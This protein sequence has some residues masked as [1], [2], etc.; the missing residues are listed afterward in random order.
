MAP[1]TG[2][3][4]YFADQQRDAEYGRAYKAAQARIRQ[5]DAL[6]RALDERRI[7]RG[8]SKAE[9]ARSAGVQPEAVR[10]LFTMNAPNPTANT[11][12]ALASALDLELVTRPTKKPTVKAK[13]AKKTPRRR[14]AARV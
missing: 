3:E 7:A 9:L 6:V 5:T 8:M 14:A 1:R 13:I 11:L 12:L 2:A 10:R 4:R